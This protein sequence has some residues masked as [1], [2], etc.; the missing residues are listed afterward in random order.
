MGRWAWAALAVVTVVSSA[1]ARV[2][3]A[4]SSATVVP[5]PYRSLPTL[6]PTPPSTI[7]DP[8][9]PVIGGDQ[10]GDAGLAVPPGTAAPPEVAATTWV[11]ADLDSGDVVAACGAHVRRRPASVQKLLL[12]AT[13]LPLLPADQ[14]VEA[15]AE[16]VALPSDSSSVGLLVGG[17]Y[18][19]ST[20]WHG[21]LLQSGNDTANALARVAGGAG[22]I[23]ATVAAMNAE[24]YRLGAEDTHASNPHGL[25]EPDQYTSAYDLALIARVDFDRADFIQYDTLAQLQWPAQPPRDPKGFQIQNENMLLRNYP[26][27]LGGKTGFTDEARH[28]YV[29]AAQRNGRRLVVT[30]MGAEISPFGRTWKQASMLLDWAFAVPPTARV[31]HLVTPEEMARRRT[32]PS[33]T[34]APEGTGAAGAAGAASAGYGSPWGILG[35]LLAL[36]ASVLLVAVVRVVRL[37]RGRRALSGRGEGRLVA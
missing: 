28:T 7:R 6:P 31:G 13:A 24:A 18:P 17:R 27:A 33:P 23:A 21:L 3:A 37:V 20:L 2:A 19:V 25:D 9:G 10:L 22:G 16:D 36:A 8:G 14:V 30:L 5:C 34:A 4:E 15:T 32:P 26:G 11:V 1:P 12:A 29:G 35:A